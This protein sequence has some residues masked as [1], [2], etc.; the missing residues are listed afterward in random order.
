MIG[1]NNHHIDIFWLPEEIML[2][3]LSFLSP[4]EIGSVNKT[5]KQFR[6]LCQKPLLWRFFTKKLC[7]LYSAPHLFIKYDKLAKDLQTSKKIQLNWK[8]LFVDMKELKGKI[9]QVEIFGG[10][11]VGNNSEQVYIDNKT[12]Y[13]N[14]LYCLP[15]NRFL[16]VSTGILKIF[17]SY[18][19]GNGEGKKGNVNVIVT[20][21]KRMEATRY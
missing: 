9:D 16:S 4:E 3:I 11:E 12:S 21:L 17:H 10:K 18:K 13:S 7:V 5:N 20:T 2:T 15:Q 8:S 6:L 19:K 1:N 14:D